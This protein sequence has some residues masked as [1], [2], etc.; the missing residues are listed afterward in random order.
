MRFPAQ[1]KVWR[2]VNVVFFSIFN[3]PVGTRPAGVF[4]ILL[5]FHLAKSMLFAPH[6]A[7]NILHH[8]TLHYSTSITGVCTIAVSVIPNSLIIY[9]NTSLESA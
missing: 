8:F 6:L 4:C 2:G 7:N 3:T 9:C 5:I 1:R